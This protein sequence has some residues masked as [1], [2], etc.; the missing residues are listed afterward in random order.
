MRHQQLSLTVATAEVAAAE[1][2]LELAGAEAISLHDAADDPVLEPAPN[3]AP[4]WPKVTLRAL[5][6]VEA[7]L[8]SLCD[9]VHAVCGARAIAVVELAEPDWQA[10]LR[11]N[12]TAR[13]VGRRLWLAPADN[14]EVP[15]GRLVVRL[16]MGLAFGTGE[17]PT[18]ALCLDWLES[19]A[20]AGDTILDYGCGSGVLALAALAL[21][22]RRAVAVDNDPQALQATR[23]N[24]DL[25]GMTERLSVVPAEA[26]PALSVDLLAAN[27]L[28]E[29]LIELAP[30]L[31]SSV[32]L[33]GRM[34]LCG[35]LAAQ[36]QSVVAAYESRFHGFAIAERHGW[37]RLTATRR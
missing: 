35:I 28:A 5:F 1:A 6:D 11:Q 15:P 17:H 32:R 19:H 29:P 33:G 34:L 27:I 13:P 22:A 4:L 7:K 12:V 16:H 21:G 31:A 36:A 25:N 37:V 20:A 24:A 14:V 9:V 2:L 23:A 30:V 26:L 8:D 3:T 10:G 18:T